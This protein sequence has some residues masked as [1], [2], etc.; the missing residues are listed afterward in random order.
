MKY[1][2]RVLSQLFILSL[3]PLVLGS[4]PIHL[5]ILIPFLVAVLYG[6]TELFAHRR[7]KADEAFIG[8][9]SPNPTL[10]HAYRED[11]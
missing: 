3:I 8:Q 11:L 2:R 4:V 6:V 1:I 7:R 10:A 9:F 5:A